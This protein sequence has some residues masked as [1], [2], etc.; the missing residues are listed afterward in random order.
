MTKANV[1]HCHFHRMKIV[2][3]AITKIGNLQINRES[4]DSS[5]SDTPNK[6]GSEEM[7]TNSMSLKKRNRSA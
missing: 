2:T 4:S 3:I 5:R 7:K 1:I 6:S